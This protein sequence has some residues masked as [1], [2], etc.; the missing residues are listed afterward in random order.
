MMNDDNEVARQDL[1]STSSRGSTSRKRYLGVRKV[2]MSEVTVFPSIDLKNCML[3]M[4]QRVLLN[5]GK[6]CILK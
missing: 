5:Y 1:F 6:C 2:L 4:Q 3:R